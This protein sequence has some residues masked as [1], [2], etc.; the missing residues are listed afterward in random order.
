MAKYYPFDLEGHDE[1]GIYDIAADGGYLY[2]A[3]YT[4]DL[5]SDGIV[6]TS[7]CQGNACTIQKIDFERASLSSGCSGTFSL[8]LYSYD[9]NCLLTYSE[10]SIY[11]LDT[12]TGKAQALVSLPNC[13]MDSTNPP[14][15]CALSDGKLATLT[16]RLSRQ[17]FSQLVIIEE[18][19]LSRT[20]IT[21]GVFSMNDSLKESAAAFN[22][23]SGQYQI[24]IRE[25]Y[26]SSM[27]NTLGKT[28]YND[29]LT[30]FH[31]DIASGD[32]PDIL[33]LYYGDLR[34]Y[35]EKGLLEDLSPYL[36]ESGLS[37]YGNVAESYTMNDRIVA[38]PGSIGVKTATVKSADVA[39]AESWTLEEML[40]FSEKHPE[41]PL[42]NADAEGLLE[43]CLT[44]NLPLFVDRETKSCNFQNELF[45]RT[46]ELGK[47]HLEHKKTMENYYTSTE[48]SL[49]P[50]IESKVHITDV[51]DPFA[52]GYIRQQYSDGAFSHI[53]YPAPEGERGLL[54][55]G[56]G[57]SYSI[58]ADSK[59]KDGAW[60]FIR[61][62]ITTT[63]TAH[64]EY[65]GKGF[66]TEASAQE[67]YFAYLQDKKTYYR[68]GNG[69]TAWHK[70]GDPKTYF[71]KEQDTE[72]EEG[73]RWY[74]MHYTLPY[75]YLIPIKEELSVMEEMLKTAVIPQ[76]Y[77]SV[78]MDLV[79]EEALIYFQGGQSAEH[80]AEL[81][82]NRVQ[83]YLDETS[84]QP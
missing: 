66:P 49:Q 3:A 18:G 36:K 67:N 21:L 40:D 1:G 17:A 58:S 30:R 73:E 6:Y 45:Y 48:F 54:L 23:E 74:Y 62:L 79:K 44:F 32:C 34:N 35:A 26:N 5:G 78:I 57:G 11:K 53:G 47:R 76:S 72:L 60:E 81:I 12:A 8:G 59:V 31:L 75:C 37:L 43:Y 25:Y 56:I 24:L 20:A 42:F 55:Y 50:F 63:Y 33:C 7:V 29:A 39:G 82:E 71:S 14:V 84:P 16:D 70:Q 38:L 19:E 41:D 68:M 65:D 15:I 77:D 13:G 27:D 2:Y 9:D 22:R 28:G 83:L 64:I 80:T 51:D 10:G 61:K 46:L 4:Q 52:E 69:L